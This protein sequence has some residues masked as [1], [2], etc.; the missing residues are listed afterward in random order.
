MQDKVYKKAAEKFANE[1]YDELISSGIL[2]DPA[3]VA[4][5]LPR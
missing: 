3:I 1:L 4:K 2:D 5:S